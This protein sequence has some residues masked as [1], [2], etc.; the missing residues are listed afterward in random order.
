M[1][2]VKDLFYMLMNPDVFHFVIILVFM[3]FVLGLKNVS[4]NQDSV[5]HHAMFLAQ[6][7]NMELSAREIVFAKTKHYATL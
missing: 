2:A 1:H 3:E 4:A 5:D 7:E 6:L